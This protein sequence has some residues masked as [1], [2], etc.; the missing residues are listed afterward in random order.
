MNGLIRLQSSESNEL[1]LTLQ[2][3]PIG[4]SLITGLR[5]KRETKEVNSN[6]YNNNQQ[7]RWEQ[8]TPHR[9]SLSKESSISGLGVHDLRLKENQS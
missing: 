2:S 3:W 9:L 1:A 8:T 4:F 5:G 6:C 7:I